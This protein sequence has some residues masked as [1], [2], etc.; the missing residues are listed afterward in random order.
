LHVLGV[1]IITP[2]QVKITASNPFPWPVT[3]KY[4]GLT[5]IQQKKKAMIIFPDGQNITVRNEKPQ[6]VSLK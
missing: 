5:V 3:V 2:Y 4:K 6:M 1:Q